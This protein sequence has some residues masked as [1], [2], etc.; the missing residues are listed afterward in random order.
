MKTLIASIVASL[1]LVGCASNETTRGSVVA[2]DP[3]SYAEVQTDSAWKTSWHGDWYYF[4][5]EENLRKFESNPT[6]YVREAGRPNPERYKV[7][8]QDV[9]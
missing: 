8:P 1:V 9:R 6:A 3:V 2:T 4:E 5:S 7:R